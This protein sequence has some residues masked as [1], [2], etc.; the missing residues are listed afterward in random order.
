M[1]VTDTMDVKAIE[2]EVKRIVEVGYNIPRIHADTEQLKLPPFI[3]QA[4][5]NK[6]IVYWSGGKFNKIDVKSL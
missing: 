1:L 2:S 6:H 5:D 3:K 4:Y